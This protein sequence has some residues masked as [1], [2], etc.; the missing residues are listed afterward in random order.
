MNINIKLNKNFTTAF[1]K[2]QDEYGEELSRI[3]GFSDEQLSYTDFIQN[4]I[5]TETVADAS[6]D[7]N[8]N[9][10]QKGIVTLINEMP[11][12]HQKLLSFNKIYH[13]INKE[14]GFKTAN[15]WLKAEWDGHL[16]MHDANTTSFLHYCYKGEGLI[17][18][19]YHEKIL[20]ISFENLYN[21][22]YEPEEYDATI[23]NMAKFPKEL[24]VLDLKEEET[25]WTEVTRVVKHANEKP[26][27]FIK[28]ANGLSQIVTED[29]PI[30]TMVGDIPAKKITTED[31]VYT[32]KPDFFE[33]GESL[34][35]MNKEIGWLVGMTLSEGSVQPSSITIKQVAGAERE[36]LL[37]ILNK[38]SMPH[39]LDKDDRIRIK[40]SPIEKFLEEMILGKTAALKQ[41]P[42]DYINYPTEFLDGIVAGMIDG[43]G[44]IDGYKNRH[45]Q[46]R[47][48]SE[49]LCHQLSTYLQTRDV[50]CGDRTP[51][52]YKSQS[53]FEQ[54]LPLFGI[55]FTLTD[56]KYFSGIGSVKIAEKYTPLVRKGSFK[57][58]KYQY[59]YGYVN[60]IENSEYIESCDEV[61]DITT[62]SGHF[63]CNGV[64]SHNCFA[65]DLKELAEKGLFFIDTFNAEPPQHLETFVDF[66]KEF[67]S[68]TC[69]R[70]S[71]AVGLPNLIPYMYY[72]WLKD[73][74][75][76]YCLGNPEKYAKQQ[77]QRLI[78][79]LNQP[80]LRG[81]IQSAFTNTSVFDRPYLEA[82]FGG[83]EFPDGSFIIDELDGIMAFQKVFLE[84]M[85]EIRSKNM[86]T[87]PV[88]TISLL[89]QD[90]KFV[91][92]EFAKYATKHNMKWND[93]NIFADSSVNSLSNCC[94]LKSNIDD[95]G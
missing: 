76:D 5:D 26:M 45:C 49:V 2:M 77:I 64:L 89:K 73:V 87:F 66:V 84:E 15:E 16:Y 48:A 81:G 52:K 31:M 20:N 8:A 28:Y 54:K 18:I 57:N 6:V 94:R 13:E 90:G 95:L 11:K 32:I 79:A 4:F 53:S 92:E 51:H 3:N 35:F 21:L 30:I 75:E 58:K 41:L 24:F 46:I 82:L 85:S 93:S 61:Y 7:G 59:Q 91:D 27:R 39:S 69:N 80:Y 14:Y 36:K 68:W 72:F 37:N 86:M 63:I 12:P 43:D 60:V 10:G 33:E 29:H 65:Y 71:G 25:I 88:N 42:P 67:V 38:Y 9:V 56:E 34:S 50:F 74:K 22:I 44:T 19:K 40:V 62:K 17:T 55:D 23:S 1:N 83:A 78:Y 70:S 47:I